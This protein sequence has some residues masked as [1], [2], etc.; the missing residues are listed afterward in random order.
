MPEPTEYSTLH[1]FLTGLSEHIFHGKLGVA[2]VQLVDYL[3][4]LLLRFAR[5]DC[6]HRVRRRTG[7]PLSQVVEMVAEANNRVGVARRE[8]HQHIGDFTL[9]WAGIYP[10]SLRRMQASDRKDFFIDYCEQGKRCY[11]IAS[12]IEG[13]EDRTSS[14]LLGR[15]SEH[16]D[17]CAYGLREIRRGWEEDRDTEGPLLL[18]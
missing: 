12:S 10:E 2:D 16:F 11:A 15:L 18:N 17:L 7:Q 8:V 6:M 4:D 5:S 3:S 13:G 1:R 9:F 14:D